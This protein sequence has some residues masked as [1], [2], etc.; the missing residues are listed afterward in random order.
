MI[1]IN[2]HDEMSKKGDNEYSLEQNCEMKSVYDSNRDLC[3]QSI[4]PLKS[5]VWF[6]IMVWEICQSLA[7]G[8][9]FPPGTPVSFT[10]KTDFH[11]ITEILV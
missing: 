2:I 9:W 3:N 5:W 6:P 10:N 4:S 7:A 8:Q 11:D 1:S